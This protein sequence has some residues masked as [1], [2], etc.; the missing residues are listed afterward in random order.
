MK[1]VADE[2]IIEIEDLAKKSRS[3]HEWNELPISTSTLTSTL[4]GETSKS[5][6]AT[7]ELVTEKATKPVS[8]MISVGG[9]SNRNALK[10]LVKKKTDN[11][12]VTSQGTE[13]TN[14]TNENTSLVHN[15]SGLT[16]ALTLLAGY[17]NYSDSDEDD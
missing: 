16:N 17:D 14:S 9:L 13:K 12:T 6:G 7:N 3:N 2:E 4:H 15:K 5:I 11:A 8:K 10:N 1:R